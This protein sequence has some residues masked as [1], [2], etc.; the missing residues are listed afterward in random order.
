MDEQKYLDG[1]TIAVRLEDIELDE[2]Q[3]RKQI[4]ADALNVLVQSIKS[5]GLI[6]NIAVRPVA[7]GKF[8]I[9]AGERRFRA[10]RELSKEN[11]KWNTVN[12]V[13]R[14]VDDRQALNL[15]LLENIHRQDLLPIERAKAIQEYGERNGIKKQKMLAEKVGMSASN[16]SNLLKMLSF[17][18][19]IIEEISGRNGVK[20]PYRE[21]LRI[22]RNKPE[23][24]KRLFNDL[25]KKV[26]KEAAEDIPFTDEEK[27]LN[28]RRLFAR[29]AREV[30]SLYSEN[31]KAFE[32]GRFN[33]ARVVLNA[34]KCLDRLSKVK[35]APADFS[36]MNS[37]GD[38]KAALE[39]L[40]DKEPKPDPKPAPEPMPKKEKKVA[41]KEKKKIK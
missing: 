33:V 11:P 13:I 22:V 37:I 24:Q 39:K 34:L 29:A 36:K 12:A 15:A 31:D 4:D 1:Q 26:T 14:L 30:E 18:K 28:S 21:L 19:D 2:N 38:V 35:D 9:V 17:D 40:L 41:R 10:F 27:S 25:K 8:K 16:L 20:Y 23:I 32:A 7:G 5:E 6:Q 3:P